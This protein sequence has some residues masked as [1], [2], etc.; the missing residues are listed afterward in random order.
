MSFSGPGGKR[1]LLSCV[2]IRQIR[3][4]VLHAKLVRVVSRVARTEHVRELRGIERLVAKMA[5][6]D[7]ERFAPP[8]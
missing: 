8:A 2:E 6:L 7:G 1:T 4:A 5:Q 3:L